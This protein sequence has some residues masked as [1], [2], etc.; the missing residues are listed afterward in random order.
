MVAQHRPAGLR[1]L[2]SRALDREHAAAPA[3]ALD[4]LRTSRRARLLSAG[5]AAPVWGV[6]HGCCQ[7]MLMPPCS[8][9]MGRDRAGTIALPR[10]MRVLPSRLCVVERSQQLIL[11]LRHHGAVK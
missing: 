1:A 11:V 3:H 5:P 4:V 8:M 2:E 10:P 9:R 6:G 7:L